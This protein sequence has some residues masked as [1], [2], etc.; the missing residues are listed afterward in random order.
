M[1]FLSVSTVALIALLAGSGAQAADMY[2]SITGA[3]MAQIMKEVGYDA[4]LGKDNEGD[5]MITG[6]IESYNYTL[7]FYRCNKQ[8]NPE[9]CL[10]L[11]F[12]SS[13]TN[14]TNVNYAALNAYNRD[15]RFGQAFFAQNGEIGLD[16][17]ATIEGGVTRQH[18]KEVI[19]WWKVTLTGFPK[20][21]GGGN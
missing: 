4:T 12:H 5:P 13:F 18:V 7:C 16:M 14:D 17:S 1:K 3:D 9:S 2:S 19:D 8:Q 15:N 21:I 6:R 11:Q 20:K 10:D